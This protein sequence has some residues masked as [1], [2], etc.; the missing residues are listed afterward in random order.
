MRA[1]RCEVVENGGDRAVIPRHEKAADEQSGEENPL[2]V[3]LNGQQ[4]KRSGEQESC[5]DDDEPAKGILSLQTVGEKASREDPEQQRE[6]SHY[7]ERE[8]GFAKAEFLVVDG[9]IDAPG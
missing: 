5:G 2:F 8:R 3:G 4:D 6:K 1:L 7:C 9:K